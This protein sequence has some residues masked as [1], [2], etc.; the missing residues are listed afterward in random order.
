M[1]CAIC[2][3]KFG[4]RIRVNVDHDHKKGNIRGLLC[5]QCNWALGRFKD[6]CQLLAR[7]KAYL[8]NSPYSMLFKKG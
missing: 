7:A 6:S 5:K 1:Q 2:G 8:E 3:I 4:G